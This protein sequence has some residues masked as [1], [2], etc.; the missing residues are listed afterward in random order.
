MGTWDGIWIGLIILNFI[1][2]LLIILIERARRRRQEEWENQVYNIFEKAIHRMEQTSS[3]LST[4]I[5]DE[6]KR[7]DENAQK[8]HN[9]LKKSYN[10][11]AD[12]LD[13][14]SQIDKRLRDIQH[15]LD[16]YILKNTTEQP[17]LPQLDPEV[18][19]V[20]D[21]NRLGVPDEE[22]AKKLGK[23]IPEVRLILHLFAEQYK[24]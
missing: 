24:P 21:L 13:L 22:I 6:V 12:Q 23:A 11:I 3:L 17:P 19:A 7:I 4:K 9:Y 5:S 1:I 15:Q 2:L 8:R 18:Q 20:L 16:R 14:A 10:D